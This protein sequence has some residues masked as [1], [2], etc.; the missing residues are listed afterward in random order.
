MPIIVNS[1]IGVSIGRWI[2]TRWHLLGRSWRLVNDGT[3]IP[4]DYGI[5]VIPKSYNLSSGKDLPCPTKAYWINSTP[6]TPPITGLLPQEPRLLLLPSFTTNETGKKYLETHAATD[7]TPA[8]VFLL[9]FTLDPGD[10][11]AIECG[12][13]T[14]CV[15][16]FFLSTLP[17]VEVRGKGWED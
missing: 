5:K 1:N 13:C 9:V 3:V 7:D 17:H 4:G 2:K 11:A 6:G 14:V 12:I 15:F 8:S 16:F 10:A